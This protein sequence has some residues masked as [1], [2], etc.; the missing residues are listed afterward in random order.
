M[1]ICW[2]DTCLLE[3]AGTGKEESRMATGL[4]R[5]HLVDQRTIDNRKR[6]ASSLRRFFITLAGASG[7]TRNLELTWDGGRSFPNTF[8]DPHVAEFH[9]RGVVVRQP[10]TE[11]AIFGSWKTDDTLDIIRRAVEELLK[12]EVQQKTVS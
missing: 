12:Y 5:E 7:L 10:I 9:A 1:A 3:E 4:I 2:H 8:T 11:V 6:C